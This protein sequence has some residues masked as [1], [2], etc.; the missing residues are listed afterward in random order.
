[1]GLGL[2]ILRTIRLWGKRTH[3]ESINPELENRKGEIREANIIPEDG[4][5]ERLA[6]VS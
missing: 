3:P 5:E 4:E 1:M 6:L 2:G